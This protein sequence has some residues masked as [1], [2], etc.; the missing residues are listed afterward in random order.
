M[1]YSRWQDHGDPEAEVRRQRTP[2]EIRELLNA[3]AYPTTD[4]CVIWASESD[5]NPTVRFGNTSMTPARAVWVMVHGD[6][7]GFLVLHTCNGGSGAQGCMNIRHLRLGTP[8]E[9]MQDRLAAGRYARGSDNP[10]SRL[11]EAQVLTIR[12]NFSAGIGVME[13][14]RRFGVSRTTINKIVYRK[15]WTH[16]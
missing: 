16:I 9:N 8:M 6:P 14:S 2:A 13:L 10:L 15:T 3:G 5:S 11:T 7:D 4:D 12:T 1:H